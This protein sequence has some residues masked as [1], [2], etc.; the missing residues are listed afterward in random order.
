MNYF[1]YT[2][3]QYVFSQA[4]NHVLIYNVILMDV[5]V[6]RDALKSTVI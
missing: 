4:N 3:H 6:I 2:S 1:I 5:E